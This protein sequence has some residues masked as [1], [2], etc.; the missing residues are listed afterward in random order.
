MEVGVIMGTS[1]LRALRSIAASYAIIR[2]AG[3]AL[4]CVGATV[5]RGGAAHQKRDET[6]LRNLTTSDTGA[7]QLYYFPFFNKIPVQ[8]PSRLLD[9]SVK[10]W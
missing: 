4:G 10:F 6:T 5:A 9:I 2:V 7:Q 8:I 3:V 1:D